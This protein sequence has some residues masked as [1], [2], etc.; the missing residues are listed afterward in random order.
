MVSGTSRAPQIPAGACER[1]TMS[2]SRE[3]DMVRRWHYLLC[4]PIV[5][6]PD[7]ALTDPG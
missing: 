5:H 1:R 6:L 2:R 4:L 7:I 3:R